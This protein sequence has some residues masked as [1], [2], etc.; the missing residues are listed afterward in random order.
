M[1]QEDCH[2]APAPADV[3]AAAGVDVDVGVG[4]APR[5]VIPGGEAVEEQASSRGKSA[6]ENGMTRC[7]GLYA[8]EPRVSEVVDAAIALVQQID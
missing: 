7:H 6:F 1:L 5:I 3:A 8:P 2:L 4:V